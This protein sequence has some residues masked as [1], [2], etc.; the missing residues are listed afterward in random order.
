MLYI[1]AGPK[2][3]LTSNASA[4]HSP[5]YLINCSSGAPHV[6]RSAAVANRGAK[7]AHPHCKPATYNLEISL[8]LR[9]SSPPLLRPHHRPFHSSSPFRSCPP[10][11]C[12]TPFPTATRPTCVAL[13]QQCGWRSRRRRRRRRR[14]G[15]GFGCW[16][17]R[18]PRG[19]QTPWPSRRR[20]P[21][22]PRSGKPSSAPA[23]TTAPWLQRGRRPRRP[24]CRSSS[25]ARYPPRS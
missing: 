10:A 1:K 12:A 5:L 18:S 19:A 6:A 14:C 13:S 4:H 21:R 20:R 23:R 2:I 8:T 24:P 3:K 7:R 11:P 25:C 9:H 17:P 22:S 16:W 15:S